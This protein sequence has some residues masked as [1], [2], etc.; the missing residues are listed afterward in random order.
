MHRHH[1][2][3]Q[4]A[5]LPFRDKWAGQGAIGD[6]FIEMEGRL[7]CGANDKRLVGSW[8][9]SGGEA[10]CRANMDTF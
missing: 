10:T 9:R 8:R 6:G 2:F 1:L 7:Q 5:L 3:G 4:S